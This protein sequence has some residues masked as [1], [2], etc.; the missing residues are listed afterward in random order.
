M[1]EGR[2]F[3]FVV[4]HAVVAQILEI[5]RSLPVDASADVFGREMADTNQGLPGVH[6][7]VKGREIVALFDQI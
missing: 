2:P 4:C 3:S 1:E 7:M 6:R 5:S